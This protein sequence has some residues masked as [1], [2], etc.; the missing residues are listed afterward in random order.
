MLLTPVG[1]LNIM[2]SKI[3]TKCKIEQPLENFHRRN[4][5]KK[6]GR[7][8]QCRSCTSIIKK[9]YVLKNKDKKASYDKIYR[10]KKAK[11]IAAFKK[12]WEQRNRNDPQF[13]LRRNLRRRIHHVLKG[14]NKSA[15]TMELLGCTVEEFIKYM[16]SLWQPGMSWDNYNPKGWH[17]DHI[18][19]C[20][21]FDLTDP[22]QQR[23]CFHYT[24]Q[25]PLWWHENL[26]RPRNTKDW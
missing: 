23:K 14:N 20:R 22:E 12:S 2:I 4:S 1:V 9:P 25:R 24:N 26:R 19:P 3:C 15:H 11:E 21:T 8:S 16:E 7:A 18:I 17:I 5:C 6:T 13:K 10:K